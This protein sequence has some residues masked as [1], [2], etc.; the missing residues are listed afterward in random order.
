MTAIRET[1]ALFDALLGMILWAK[2]PAAP[3]AAPGGGW[4][5]IFTM[6]VP[7]LALMWFLFIRPAQRQEKDRKA[8]IATLK[9]NDR[10]IAAGGILGTVAHIKENEDEV[11]LKVDE[12]RIRVLRSSIVRVIREEEAAKEQPKANTPS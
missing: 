4:L 1:S 5:T 3:E 10:V 7:I 6:W 9:K 8:M 11:T 12:G 2:T